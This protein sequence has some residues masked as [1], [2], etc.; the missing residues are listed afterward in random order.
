MTAPGDFGFVP[1]DSAQDAA[2]LDGSAPDE[3]RTELDP[4]DDDAIDPSDDDGIDSLDDVVI[5][6]SDDD[7]ID[8]PNRRVYELRVGPNPRRVRLDVFVTGSVE[9][10]TRT[11]VQ[12]LIEG[13]GVLVNDRPVLKPGRL[14]Q[15]GDRVTCSVPRSAPQTVEAE[16]IPLDIVYEDDDV[17][18][19]NK[20]AG[21]VTHPA[22]GNYSG[23]LVNALMH[24]TSRLSAERG[25]ERAGILHRLDKG[26]SG[27]LCVAKTDAAHRFI[28]RQF[29]E[30]SID[31][32]YE[33]VVWGAFEHSTGAIEAPIARHRSDRK[34]MAVVE[35]GKEAVTEYRLI[36]SFEHLSHL[37]L[38][39]RTGRTHQI[40]VHLSHLHHPVF[41][42]PTY[43]GRR[44]LYGTVT[45]KYKT[46]I[47]DLLH[48]LP[49]QALHAKT[50]GF[51]HPATRER[52]FFESA[53]PAD[54]EEVLCRLRSE[55]ETAR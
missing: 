29:A 4:S 18:V 55:L 46:L 40:R 30:H 54:M 28:A 23:T 9:N 39:L 35:G 21:M 38:R 45:Q 26:T 2:G 25:V 43:G 10:A 20:P 44:I 34:K 3:V 14:L 41:G 7:G 11:R 5:E 36:E 33:A 32:E 51:V 1:D 17:L 31:R 27:L 19:V 37:R 22:H 47:A 13:G 52:V 24:Y 15:P 50:L 53:L 42:D 16:D 6:P 12:Q 49:R 48:I 8:S